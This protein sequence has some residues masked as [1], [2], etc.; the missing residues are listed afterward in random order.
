MKSTYAKDVRTFTGG[1]TLDL[2]G[3]PRII[4]QPGHS[5][6]SVA[7]HLPGMDALFVA[8]AMTTRNVLT[9]QEGPG[10]ARFTDDPALAASS[11]AGLDGLEVHWLLPGPGSPWDKGVAEALR[12]HLSGAQQT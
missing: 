12:R 4:P 1:E 5:P 2:P 9:G 7:A 6:G 3:R 10:P 8:D 11:L